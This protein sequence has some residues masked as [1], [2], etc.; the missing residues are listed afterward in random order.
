MFCQLLRTKRGNRTSLPTR[1]CTRGL[2]CVLPTGCH[3][4]GRFTV[5]RAVPSPGPEGSQ[6]G[7]ARA[8][9]VGTA[10]GPRLP[11][12]PPGGL[13]PAGRITLTSVE[14]ASTV[15]K[16]EERDGLF[17]SSLRPRS[18][19]FWACVTVSSRRVCAL[20]C[21]AAVVP[22]AAAGPGEARKPCGS[23]SYPQGTALC[24]WFQRRFP[25]GLFS[26]H[27]PL[28]PGYRSLPCVTARRGPIVTEER[29]H[30]SHVG[31]VY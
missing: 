13:H 10:Q 24:P 12:E 6:D 2:C 20:T 30:A 1:P 3:C 22:S 16:E 18:C 11:P 9:A 17:S 25:S 19:C 31:A 29:G 14:M 27:R 26:S 5:T 28:H 15:S 23:C 21:V 8:G 4:R 7:A